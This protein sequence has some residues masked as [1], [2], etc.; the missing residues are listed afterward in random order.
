MAAAGAV[1][2]FAS[3]GSELP[4]A[5][6]VRRLHQEGRRVLLPFL[7]EGTMDATELHPWSA[8]RPTTYG[9]E[10]PSDAIAADP[11][12]IDVVVAPGLAFDA[13]GYRLGFGGGHYDR[14]L[15]RLRID[16][17]LVGIGFD[18][19]LVEEVP[20]LPE[21]V[22]LDVIVTDARTVRVHSESPGP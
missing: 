13:C 1:M 2:V 11:H 15:V 9:P 21:D 8:M 6:I 4:T 7:H 12:G 5:G 10:E 17:S 20:H 14:Y 16:A 3:F 22:P 19:Q 18:A